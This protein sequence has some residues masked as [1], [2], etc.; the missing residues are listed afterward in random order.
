MEALR[1]APIGRRSPVPQSDFRQED[2]AGGVQPAEAGGKGVKNIDARKGDVCAT[3]VSE[4][5]VPLV[6]TKEG[7]MIRM[8]AV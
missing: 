1:T 4:K 6:T 2:G 7:V 5:E 3:T 8:P